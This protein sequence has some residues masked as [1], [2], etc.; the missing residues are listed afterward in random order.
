MLFVWLL[1][2]LVVEW[3]WCRFGSVVELFVWALTVS[4]SPQAALMKY[5][6]CTKTR[7]SG[8]RYLYHILCHISLI[9]III[10]KIMFNKDI[11]LP[12]DGYS[13]VIEAT[14]QSEK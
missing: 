3:W 1:S 9:I 7:T 12:F 13:F 11:L 10:T 14:E 4:P 8:L 5:N 2:G 6:N